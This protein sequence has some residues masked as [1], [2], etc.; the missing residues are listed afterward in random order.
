MIP[1]FKNVRKI[2]TDKKYHPV[3]LLSAVSRA[4]E[5]LVNKNIA[6]QL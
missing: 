1:V 5:R 4:F 6:D 2:S 3:S